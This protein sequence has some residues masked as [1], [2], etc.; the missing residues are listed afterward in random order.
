[1]KNYL[2]F[3]KEIYV[4]ESDALLLKISIVKDTQG[5]CKQILGRVPDIKII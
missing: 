1:M 3:V 4:K 2:C 5:K